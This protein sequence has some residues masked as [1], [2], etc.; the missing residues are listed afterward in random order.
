LTGA[1]TGEFLDAI[2]LLGPDHDDVLTRRS[3]TGRR[4]PTVR[5]R[6]AGDSRA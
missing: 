5:W 3:L 4:P 2:G 6:A 1:G